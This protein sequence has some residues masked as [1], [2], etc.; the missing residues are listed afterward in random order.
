MRLPALALMLLASLAPMLAWPAEERTLRYDGR[1]RHYIVEFPDAKAP[2]PAIIV[3]HGAGGTAERLRRATNFSLDEEGWVEVYP[4]AIGRVWSDGRSLLTV[5]ALRM[6]DD[7]GFVRALLA[8]L[9]AEGRVDPDRVFFA[10]LS[11]GGAM[12]LV[13]ICQA[14]ELVAG[15]AVHIMTLPV[16][17]DC[18]PRPPVPLMFVLGTHDPLIPF[19]GGWIR[20]GGRRPVRRALCR[21]DLGLLRQ[22]QSLQRRVRAPA[23]RP[24]PG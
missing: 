11:N 24:G 14:P 22:A 19:G 6:G 4:D 15:A 8:E 9:V 7:V 5:G 20:F 10:G 16:G 3:F 17:L 12:T 18:P 21:P 23:G 1:E 13:L 2:R